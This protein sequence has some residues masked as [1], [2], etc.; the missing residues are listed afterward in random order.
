[1]NGGFLMES[2]DLF[3]RE[4]NGY[5]V[6][7]V[8]KYIDTLKAQYRKVF[9]YAKK[10]ETDNEKLKRICRKMSEENKALKAS[11]AVAGAVSGDNS[12]VLESVE[13]MARLCDALRVEN[14]AL[15]DKLSK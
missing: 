2:K 13:K 12:D 9:E 4:E 7:D 6:A 10:N 14:A 11:G 5:N 1:M 3:R 15:K 8:E